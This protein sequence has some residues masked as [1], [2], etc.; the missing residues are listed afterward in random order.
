[1]THVRKMLLYLFTVLIY[2]PVLPENGASQGHKIKE[3]GRQDS[4]RDKAVGYSRQ[5]RSV[6]GL[7][8]RLHTRYFPFAWHWCMGSIDRQF[9]AGKPAR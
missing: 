2:T 6:D 8:G 4:V 7:D 9:L 5:R 3:M 1:M